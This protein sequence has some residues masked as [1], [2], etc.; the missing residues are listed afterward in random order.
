M[1]KKITHRKMLTNHNTQHAS[2]DGAGYQ[3]KPTL[4]GAD[5][6]LF[7]GVLH[8]EFYHIK[9]IS[10]S[11]YTGRGGPIIIVPTLAGADPSLASGVLHRVFCYIK[12]GR[13]EGFIS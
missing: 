4:A 3:S 7:S 6:S 8:R 5:P 10:E 12:S 1:T 2:Y 9:V 11:A 13:V